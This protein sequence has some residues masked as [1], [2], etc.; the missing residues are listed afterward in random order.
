MLNV[1][2][3]SK[4]RVNVESSYLPSQLL[5]VEMAERGEGHGNT[6]SCGFALNW[7]HAVRL[8]IAHYVSSLVVVVIARVIAVFL[9]LVRPSAHARLGAA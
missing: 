9:I 2:V 6:V 7:M 8:S 3:K 5:S 1:N 4:E